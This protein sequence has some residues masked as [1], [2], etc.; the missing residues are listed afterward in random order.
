MMENHELVS[1]QGKRGAGTSFIVA[2]LDLEHAGLKRLKDSSYLA[3]AK[4]MLGYV[5]NE[6]NDGKWLD[7]FHSSSQD[8]TTGHSRNAFLLQNDP[9]APDGGRPFRATQLK[10]QQ[11]CLAVVT[12]PACH[13]FTSDS[14]I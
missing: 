12:A 8:R 4:R 3:L 10:V 2:E 7:A 5:L 1:P 13:S 14:G 6:C 11:V 9:T